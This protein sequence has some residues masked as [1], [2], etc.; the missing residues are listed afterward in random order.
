MRVLIKPLE[1]LKKEN[2]SDRWCLLI[3][4]GLSYSQFM[5]DSLPEDRIIEV[6]EV[7]NDLLWRI[8]GKKYYIKPSMIVCITEY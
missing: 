6:K 3:I 8:D 2:R 5:E 7:G 4:D 1:V